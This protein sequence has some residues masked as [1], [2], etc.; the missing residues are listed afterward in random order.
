MALRGSPHGFSLLATTRTCGTTPIVALDRNITIMK[1]LLTK[2]LK[3][4]RTVLSRPSRRVRRG[5]PALLSLVMAMTFWPAD[6]VAQCQPEWLPGWL[7]TPSNE[8]F[9]DME[10]TP[11]GDLIVC[12]SF[13]SPFSRVARWDGMQWTSLASGLASSAFCTTTLPDGRLAVG[14]TNAVMAWDGTAWTQLGGGF[15]GI[16]TA[17]AVRNGELVVAGQFTLAGSTSA[18]HIAR[19]D[20]TNWL[21]LGSGLSGGLA[22]VNELAAL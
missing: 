5:R 1:S 6:A 15:D 9:A 16:V 7:Q 14:V 11:N 8:Y 10:V 3:A 18:S 21:P 13:T 22:G 12:G 20:G 2:S 17:M 4:L 19:W